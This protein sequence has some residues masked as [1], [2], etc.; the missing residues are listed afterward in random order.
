MSILCASIECW[1][2]CSSTWHLLFNWSF[3]LITR[4]FSTAKLPICSTNSSLTV[5]VDND[6][7]ENDSS[8]LI[9]FVDLF[10]K[11]W[12]TLQY[13]WHLWLYFASIRIHLFFQLC[14]S[15][16][17][18]SL[19]DWSRSMVCLDCKTLVS[20]WSN[21][22]CN[23]ILVASSSSRILLF[24][25]FSRI[26]SLSIWAHFASSLST[27]SFHSWIICCCCWST[28]MTSDLPSST[29]LFFSMCWLD[30]S[31]SDLSVQF[32]WLESSLLSIVTSL[33]DFPSLVSFCFSDD[34][35]DTATPIY[36]ALRS[37]SSHVLPLPLSNAWL[38]QL[39]STMLHLLAV[40]TRHEDEVLR[41]KSWC[42][43]LPPS[44]VLLLLQLPND[45]KKDDDDDKEESDDDD[46]SVRLVD[47]VR[48]IVRPFPLELLLLVQLLSTV[49]LSPTMGWLAMIPP[50]LPCRP[51]PSLPLWL[52]QPPSMVQVQ[53]TSWM[54]RTVVIFYYVNFLTL[55]TQRDMMGREADRQE[56]HRSTR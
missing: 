46:T 25:S 2:S 9:L 37:V 44:F 51:R 45:E 28:A 41:S 22:A 54:T 50:L 8:C 34:D 40:P 49:L 52:P 31:N 27:L 36:L 47:R 14:N 32:I 5:E 6:D 20:C 29:S 15:C 30:V 12:L 38:N 13:S 10:I 24:S 56:R 53:P 23:L 21:S 3:S 4:P 11:D 16:I 39:G 19:S 42:F 48:R 18:F 1:Y 7:V 33:E 26:S 17:I 35:F 55:V 43:A